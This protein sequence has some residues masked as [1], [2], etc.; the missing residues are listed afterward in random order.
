M[1]KISSIL[2]FVFISLCSGQHAEEKE[3]H[4]VTLKNQ[5]AVMSDLTKKELDE[6]LNKKILFKAN[7]AIEISVLLDNIAQINNGFGTIQ[8]DTKLHGGQTLNIQAG[9]HSVEN[10]LMEICSKLD[11]KLVFDKRGRLLF[12][13]NIRFPDK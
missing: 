8:I 2:V 11:A 10:I 3:D 5:A 12:K 13:S 6:F 1:K 9:N 4:L 7:Q